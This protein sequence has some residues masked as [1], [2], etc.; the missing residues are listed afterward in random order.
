MSSG[1]QIKMQKT[2]LKRQNMNWDLG[3]NLLDV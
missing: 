2:R 3:Q 1:K